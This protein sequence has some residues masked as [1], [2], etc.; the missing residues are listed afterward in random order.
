M[1]PF[2]AANPKSPAA[3]CVLDIVVRQIVGSKGAG[4]FWTRRRMRKKL[5][6]NVRAA[7]S[8]DAANEAAIYETPSKGG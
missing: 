3:R 1:L 8:P 4:G 7:P 6:Q 2:V 5:R